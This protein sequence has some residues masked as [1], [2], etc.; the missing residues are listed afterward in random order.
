MSPSLLKTCSL[1]PSEMHQFFNTQLNTEFIFLFS[2]SKVG[3]LGRNE[4][5]TDGV[6][7]PKKILKN[8]ET[9]FTLYF[10]VDFLDTL[11]RLRRLELHSEFCGADDFHHFRRDDLLEG[12]PSGESQ[13]IGAIPLNRKVPF[14]IDDDVVILPNFCSR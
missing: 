13:T 4:P 14:A 5:P 7:P 3:L 1:Q 6:T 8:Q 2:A 9:K 11:G 10:I 12:V